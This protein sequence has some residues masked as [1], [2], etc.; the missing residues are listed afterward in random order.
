[1]YNSLKPPLF[2]LLITDSDCLLEYKQKCCCFPL[3][4]NWTKYLSS[5]FILLPWVSIKCGVFLDVT[6]DFF[7][8]R[9]VIRQDI[10]RYFPLVGLFPWCWALLCSTWSGC[11][12]FLCYWGEVL[13]TV[14][15]SKL[16][17]HQANF[18][19]QLPQSSPRV[20]YLPNTN[21]DQRLMRTSSLTHRSSPAPTA[22]HTL[23]GQSQ[24]PCALWGDVPTIP[25]GPSLKLH[26]GL[27]WECVHVCTCVSGW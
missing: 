5:S 24:H 6:L 14:R 10:G 9:W 26:H 27:S 3:Q 16:H 15:V 23:P 21:K 25:R 12:V 22:L 2:P 8:T 20:P 17:K 11:A 13:K 19:E 7:G 1:M 18:P 4:A